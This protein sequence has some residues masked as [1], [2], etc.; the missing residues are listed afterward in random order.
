MQDGLPFFPIQHGI[1]IEEI[2]NHSPALAGINL[3][4]LQRPHGRADSRVDVP[5]AE[6]SG[7]SNRR[8]LPLK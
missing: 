2:R 3:L 4:E 7:K 5:E 1:T 8:S 6:R